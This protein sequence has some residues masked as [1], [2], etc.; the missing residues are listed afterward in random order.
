MAFAA[1]L[2]FVFAPQ[3]VGLFT[4]DQNVI[5]LGTN[6]LRITA[7][8]YLF[9]PLGVVLGQGLAGAG[10]TIAPMFITLL[11]LWGFQ[12]P[13]AIF[14]SKLWG[15][16]GIWWANALASV[17]HGIFLMGWFETGRWKKRELS[18]IV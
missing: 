14:L 18:S 3:I 8:F 10:D 16:S 5:S 7:P 17:L 12:V 15:T 4:K 1:I 9:I 6:F 2:F 11:S 13:M